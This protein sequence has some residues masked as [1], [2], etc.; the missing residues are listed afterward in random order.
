MIISKVED[1]FY[2]HLVINTQTRT[3]EGP[4]Y[5]HTTRSKV[6]VKPLAEALELSIKMGLLLQRTMV[7][8]TDPASSSQD[9][10]RH[11]PTDEIPDSSDVN[12]N[13]DLPSGEMPEV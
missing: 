11:L 10:S 12:E 8:P 2:K 6:A 9:V 5:V 4:N 13:G 7:V 1:T 3:F